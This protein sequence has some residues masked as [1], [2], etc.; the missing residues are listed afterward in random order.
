MR[1]L[2]NFSVT[3]GG[4]TSRVFKGDLYRHT[5]L[6][7]DGGGRMDGSILDFFRYMIDAAAMDFGAITDHSAGG[8]YEYW[9]W[10]IQKVTEVHHAP[11]KYWSLFG[12]ERTPHWPIGHKNVIHALPNIPIVKLFSGRTSPNTGRPMRP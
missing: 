12:Y 11:G 1:Q 9:W 6:S 8:D 4:K 5:E 7:T 3:S 2:R 10:L